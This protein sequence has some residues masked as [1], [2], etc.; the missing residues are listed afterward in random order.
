[1]VAGGAKISDA[2]LNARQASVTSSDPAMMLYTSGTTGSARGALLTHRSL[3]NNAR[4]IAECW[5]IQ[6]DAAMCVLV[7]FLH[8]MD[9]VA[10]TRLTMS[11]VVSPLPLKNLPQILPISLNISGCLAVF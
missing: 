11:T 5:D 9:S 8:A 7:P 10:E 6:Q 1:M 2:R 4:F 3:L